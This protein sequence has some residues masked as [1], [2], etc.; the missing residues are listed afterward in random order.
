[1]GLGEYHHV[2]AE[3]S[4][5]TPPPAQATQKWE[6]AAYLADKALTP[7]IY[8][9]ALAITPSAFYGYDSW[10]RHNYLAVSIAAAVIA[11]LFGLIAAALIVI[12]LEEKEWRAELD[13]SLNPKPAE[14]SWNSFEQQFSEYTKQRKQ[15]K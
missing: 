14:F 10:T 15:T 11:I 6:H 13:Q 4:S 9:V 7:L 1:M 3:H 2:T 5:L 12:K 8:A